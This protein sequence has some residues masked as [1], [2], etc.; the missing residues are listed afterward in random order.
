MKVYL[1]TRI[2]TSHQELENQRMYLKDYCERNDI[3]IVQTFED[4]CSGAN[5]KRD[6]LDDL[7]DACRKKKVDAVICFSLSRLGRSLQ[8]ILLT[9]EQF[10]NMGIGFISVT[11]GIDTSKKSPYCQLMIS[12]L[13]GLASLE[14]ELIRDRVKAGIERAKSKN[15]K[16]G[17]PT[18]YVNMDQA[19]ILRKENMSLRKI[20]KIMGVSVGLLCKK[21]KDIEEQNILKSGIHLT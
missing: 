12:I 11:E 10:T 6:G 18:K 2:S 1:Y 14:R 17:R 16:L 20:A 3:E 15:I 19:M 7:L 5:T 9:I 13:G 8:H 21:F 4:I